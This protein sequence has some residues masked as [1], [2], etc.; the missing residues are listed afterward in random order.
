M[1]HKDSETFD[2]DGIVMVSDT[3]EFEAI[4]PDIIPE[5]IYTSV[6]LRR[7]FMKTEEYSKE[8]KREELNENNEKWRTLCAKIEAYNEIIELIKTGLL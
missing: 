3:G 7:L 1:T 8:A 2:N 4:N 5:K 6:F